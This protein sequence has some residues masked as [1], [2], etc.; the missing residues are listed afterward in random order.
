MDDIVVIQNDEPIILEAINDL[1][2][3]VESCQ[4][5]LPG[6]DGA[7]TKLVT[8]RLPINGNEFTLPSLPIGGFVFDSVQLIDAQG[9]VI[10]VT[11]VAIVLGGADAVGVVD[12]QDIDLLMQNGFETT[13]VVCSYLERTG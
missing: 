5:G 12:Q 10:D 1:V 11:G 13:G 6:R 3:V 7:G 4:Q 8:Y 2:I 9:A